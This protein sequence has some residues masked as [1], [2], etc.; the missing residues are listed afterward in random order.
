MSA[1][2]TAI[3]IETLE[4]LEKKILWLSSYTIHNAN[5]LRSNDDGIKV[6]GHQAS[7]AS[8]STILT[9]LYLRILRPADRVAVKPHASPVFHAIQYLLGTQDL[10][11]LKNFR[12]FGGA[13]SYPSRTK[14]GDDVDFSTG[15]VGLGVAITAFASIV[16]D[17]IKS[18]DW[19]SDWPE[20]R[21]IA[22]MGDAELDEGN[23]YEALLEGWKYGLRNCWWV[24]DYNRQS[25]DSVVNDQLFHKHADTFRNLGWEV[26]TLKHG[27]QQKAFFE[28]KGGEKLRDWIDQCPNMLFSALTFEGGAAWR[29]QLHEDLAGLTDTLSAIDA[30]S[31]D[32]LEALMTNLGGHDMGEIVDAFE[33]APTDKPVCFI[34]YTVKGKGLP[35]KGHKD[36][37][38]GLMTKTQMQLFQ[39]Q[40]N[41]AEGDEWEPFAGMDLDTQKLS[42]Q[43]NG[44]PFVQKGRRRLAGDIIPVGRLPLPA[45]RGTMS[46]QEGF[47]KILN[48]IAKTDTPLADRIVTTSPDVTVSTNLGGWVNSRAL[49]S[50]ETKGDVFRERKLMS[51]QKWDAGPKGQHMELGIAENNLLLLLGAMGL[52]HSLFGERLIPIGTLYDPFISR[53]L[54]SL[55]YACYQD[56]RFM[57]VATPAGISLAPEGGAH[58]SIATPLIGM[59]QDGLASFEPTYVDELAV[60][61]EW[62]FD[63]I[64]RDGKT[65]PSNSWERDRDGGSVYLRLSTK[66]VDQLVRDFSDDEKQAIIEGGYWMRPPREGTRLVIAYTGVMG[67]EASEAM[68]H[69]LQKN[70]DA[71]LLSITSADR[72]NAGWNASRKAHHS[73]EGIFP[74]RIERL[75]DPLAR[76]ARIIT[77][78]DGHPLSLAWLGS[79]RGHRV[80]PL[81]VEHFGQTGNLNDLYG[82]HRIDVD[83]IIDAS[84]P[85]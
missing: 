80:E 61:M 39:A 76:D 1:L 25:L 3:D 85:R 60:I 67:P 5:H 34:A 29:K 78:V 36:N 66:P 74:S 15:S 54:D 18:R 40:N 46:T 81:G 75:F 42:R 24:I 65:D 45:I 72:L 8:L 14:D 79:V 47:G 44:I 55:N 50:R 2:N 38:S 71:A 63:Y 56:A 13:Q 77:V 19:K 10:D 73:G 20:G 48:E 41:V 32:D 84:R 23:I 17:Y 49:F 26:I 51:A 33:N 70:P 30:L 83:A 7:S 59:S 21:M 64:Q 52:S 9:A 27:R 43:L 57:L 35:L 69:I 16:Q 82:H 28:L 53:G 37:H 4:A 11:A 6:G 62:A 22:L 58:Q 31:D 68:G 12:G